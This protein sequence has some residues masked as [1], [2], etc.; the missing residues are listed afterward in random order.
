MTED[1]GVGL[2]GWLSGPRRKTPIVRPEVDNLVLLDKHRIAVLPMTNISPDPNDDFFADGLTEE[3][4][5]ELSGLPG[6][7]VI[8]RTSV[9]HYKDSKKSVREIARDLRVGSVLE[10]SVRKAGN[11][12]RIT[13]QLIDGENEEHLWAQRFDRDL[14]DIFAVQSEI[15]GNVA[16]ALRLKLVPRHTPNKPSPENL[17]V[18]TLCLKARFLWNKR[19]KEGIE[20]AISLF[21]EALKLDPDSARVN[22]GL[23]DCYYI[24]A[25]RRYMDVDEGEMKAMEFVTK[26]LKL[27]PSL[28]DA[29]ATLGLILDGQQKYS[30]A[31]KEYGTA[32]SL[33]P[34]YASAHQWYHMLLMG[35]GRLREGLHEIE[36]AA[37]LDPLSP[38]IN[39]NLAVAY[40]AAGRLDDSMSVINKLIQTEPGWPDG[41]AIRSYG[42]AKRG[43]R[44]ESLA[45][46]EMF[47][48]LTGD[49]CGY[50]VTRAE[51]EALLDNKEEALR[52]I[53]EVTPL[54]ETI[55]NPRMVSLHW[56]WAIIGDKEQFFKWVNWAIERKVAPGVL[57]ARDLRYFPYFNAMREDPRFPELF[58]KLNLSQ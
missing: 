58:K 35:T 54:I 49:E 57:L 30:E 24:A 27:D 47:Y 33:N 13:A 14:N 37:E 39:T 32:I 42:H 26:A 20:Q 41:Y 17:D 16:K 19:T 46:V 2:K 53:E 55:H 21:E 11:R 52:L 22:A 44:N 25:D 18:Y 50:K 38:I 6:V 9:M 36:K 45:D 7:G 15:A 48:K 34:N 1:R 10:G 4:I 5:T 51:C 8:A 56:F 12:I 29:H 43:L 31:E 3:M 28:P 40:L 23:A